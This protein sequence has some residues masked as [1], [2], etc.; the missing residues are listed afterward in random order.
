MTTENTEKNSARGVTPLA[1]VY[2][3]TK[4]I[5]PPYPKQYRNRVTAS[6]VTRQSTTP[7]AKARRSEGR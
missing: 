1:S 2:S 3:A 6:M 7:C 5:T 4:D